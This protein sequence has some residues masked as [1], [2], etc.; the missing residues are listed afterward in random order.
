MASSFV[1]YC[2]GLVYFPSRDHYVIQFYFKIFKTSSYLQI[3]DDQNCK[4]AGWGLTEHD[5]YPED[6]QEVDV[7]I[8]NTAQ[9]EKEYRRLSQTNKSGTFDHKSFRL[10]MS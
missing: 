8:R 9:C 3:L 1:I 7:P 4:V 10:F 6:L 5:K 2:D